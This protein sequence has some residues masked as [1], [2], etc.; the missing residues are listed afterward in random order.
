VKSW[1]S[2]SEQETELIGG[3]IVVH[4]PAEGV[5]HL[6]GDLGAGKT[7]LVRA[8]AAALG[9]DPE[10]VAS[11]TY[12]ILHEYPRRSAPPILH[13]DCYRLS[14]DPREWEEIGLAET[15]SGPG[16]KFVEWP[17]EALSR[18]AAP[19]AVIEIAIGEE[20]EREVTFTSGNARSGGR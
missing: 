5:I 11:P 7:T 1:T 16:L 4:L 13:L 6:S 20:D 18:Y 12:A 10:E 15:L 9:A 3:A 14:D 19:A 2:R 17:K 8:M